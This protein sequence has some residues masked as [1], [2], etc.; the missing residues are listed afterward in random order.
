MDWFKQ[1]SAG[2]FLNPG[3][4]NMEIINR[5]GKRIIS[6]SFIKKWV[7]GVFRELKK[8]KMT[9]SSR[10]LNLVFVNSLEMKKLNKQFRS[11][12]KPTDV[13]SFSFLK[14]FS[15]SQKEL[16][17][18]VLCLPYIRQMKQGPVRERTAYAI[19]HGILHLLG[20]E[21]EKNPQSAQKMYR[22]QDQIFDKLYK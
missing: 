9:F 18:L 13:L 12:N 15:H 16:G 14:S 11:K 19:L 10:Q 6:H 20:F 21:H 7:R 5:S 8:R 2:A 17:E 3:F 1:W 22:L 4:V